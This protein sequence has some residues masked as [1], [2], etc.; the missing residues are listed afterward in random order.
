MCAVSGDMD[1]DVEKVCL[2]QDPELYEQAVCAYDAQEKVLQA[3]RG[4]KRGASG[5]RYSRKWPHKS[6]KQIE[7]PFSYVMCT[8]DLQQVPK[9]PRPWEDYSS[10]GKGKDGKG[11][12]KG[13]G[14]NRTWQK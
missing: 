2:R 13:G 6:N 4:S 9:K 12:G 1:F 10:K 8:G 11:K 14:K 7:N 3:K 5:G